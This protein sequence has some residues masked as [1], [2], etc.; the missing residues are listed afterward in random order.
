MASEITYEIA[1]ESAPLGVKEQD[2]ETALVVKLRDLKYT[3][4]GDSTL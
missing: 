4:H 1:P 2:I 3:R